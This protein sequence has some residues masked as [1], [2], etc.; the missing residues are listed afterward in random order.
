MRTKARGSEHRMGAPS[1]LSKGGGW[2][3]YPMIVMIFRTST[4][5]RTK[6]RTP[7]FPLGKDG[8]PA[9]STVRVDRHG[10]PVSSGS[11]T[12]IRLRRPS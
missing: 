3:F 11:L 8:A 6:V 10:S 2:M 9:P 12:R 4:R 7:T 1:L 5:Y